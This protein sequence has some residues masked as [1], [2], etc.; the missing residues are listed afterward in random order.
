LRKSPTSLRVTLRQLRMGVSL[1]FEDCMRL[2]YRLVQRFMAGGDFFEGVRSVV[3]DK[4]NAPRWN[5][6][7]LEDVDPACIDKYF[8]TLGRDELTFEE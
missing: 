3:I 8:A 7:R 5:P 1:D 6:A 4:D 2:E